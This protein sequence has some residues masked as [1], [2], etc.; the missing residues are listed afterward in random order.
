MRCTNYYIGDPMKME[1]IRFSTRNNSEC[2]IIFS[3][4][5]YYLRNLNGAIRLSELSVQVASWASK[6]E[7]KYNQT[8]VLIAWETADHHIRGLL[9]Q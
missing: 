8:S 9:P 3:F 6:W 1:P 5:R 4:A 7:V 2:T